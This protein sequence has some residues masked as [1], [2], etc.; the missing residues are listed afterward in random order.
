MSN[1]SN[2]VNLTSTSTTPSING[3]IVLEETLKNGT[4]NSTAP[5]FPDKDSGML[6]RSFVVLIGFTI[7]ILIY[8]GVR[9]LRY[10]QR[11]HQKYYFIHWPVFASILIRKTFALFN[12]LRRN[13]KTRRYGIVARKDRQELQRL[14]T[15]DDE[16]DVTLPFD[17]AGYKVLFPCK[18]LYFC[19][20]GQ[21][22][23]TNSIR[24]VA[25][26]LLPKLSLCFNF[27][28]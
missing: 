1:S 15:N 16:E 17:I 27:N 6:T 19:N 28:I 18:T 2:S 25:E 5:S 22:A 12:R 3:S 4:A 23:R 26:P 24:H 11:K 21:R 9:A 8:F 7:V 10:V 20:H 13:Q 14:D